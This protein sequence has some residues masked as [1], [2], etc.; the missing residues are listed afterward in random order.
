MAAD[1]IDAA[2]KAALENILQHA[3]DV[4]RNEILG[5]VMLRD[6]LMESVEDLED[7]YLP[8]H[9]N[10]E[11]DVA[12]HYDVNQLGLVIDC[13]LSNATWSAA[14]SIVQRYTSSLTSHATT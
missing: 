7:F 9:A 11:N 4:D 1:D 14:T 8:N 5:A 2:V 12:S 10:H 6:I 3:N 13:T